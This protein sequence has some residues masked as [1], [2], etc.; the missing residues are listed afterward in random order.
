M[1]A[2]TTYVGKNALETGQVQKLI[3]G[4]DYKGRICGYSKSVIDRF[5]WTV[6]AWDGSGTCVE[7]CPNV[8]NYA[9]VDWFD[10]NH[11]KQLVCK[12]PADMNVTAIDVW[13]NTLEDTF[14]MDLGIEIAPFPLLLVLSGDC[15][16]KFSS[17]NYLGFCVLDDMSILTNLFTQYIGDYL[18]F[19]EG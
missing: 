4:L 7:T 9:D 13:I 15:M 18:T 5:A 12:D 17:T 1:W 6:V 19:P 2:A 8:T 10:S 14:G 16:F 3:G 11:V